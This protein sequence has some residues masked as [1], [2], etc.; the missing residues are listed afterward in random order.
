MKK[1][2]PLLLVFCI[3]ISISIA[4]KI[5]A[6]GGPMNKGFVFFAPETDVA[7]HPKFQNDPL[8]NGTEFFVSWAQVE[9]KEGQYDWS[10]IEKYAKEYSDKGKKITFRISTASFSPN[11]SP[12]WLFENYNVRRITNG[13][14]ANFENGL[15]G[16][17]LLAGGKLTTDSNLVVSGNSS[18]TGQGQILSSGSNSVDDMNS[19]SGYNIGFDFLAKGNAIIK[20]AVKKEDGSLVTIKQWSVS[21]GEKGSRNCFLSSDSI[22]I[23]A[24]IAIVSEN[25][26]ISLDNINISSAKSGFHVGNLAFPNYLDPVFTTKLSNMIKALAQKYKNDDRVSSVCIGGFGRWEELTLGGDIGR[27]ITTDMWKTLGFEQEKYIAHIK[28]IIDVFDSEFKPSGK[29][30]FMCAIG[31]PTEGLSDQTYIDWKITNYLGKKGIGI[32]YNG[33]QAMASE[34]G[35]DATAIFYQMNRF[36]HSPNVNMYYEQ[37]AQINSTVSEVVGHPLSMYNRAIIDQ[38]DYYWM[39]FKDMITPFT[40]KYMQYASES[41]GSALVTRMYNFPDKVTYNS[42]IDKNTYTLYNQWMGIFQTNKSVRAD[43]KGIY[44]ITPVGNYSVVQGKK[45]M[46]GQ[47]KYSIEDRQ[48]YNGMYGAVI[49]MEYLD[50]KSGEF[51]VYCIYEGNRQKPLG[52][53]KKSGTGKWVRKSFYDPGFLAS[54]KNGGR[55]MLTEI[56]ITEGATVSSIGIDFVPAREWKEVENAAVRNV[57]S[58]GKNL[59]DP[60]TLT[61]PYNKVNGTSGISVFVTPDGQ[62]YVSVKTTVKAVRGSERI[63]LTTKEYYMPENAD[64]FYVTTANAPQ[65]TT[66]LEVEVSAMEGNAFLATD[67][68]GKISYSTYS[69]VNDI[70]NESAIKVNSKNINLA[71][72]KPFAGLWVQG[73]GTVKGTV[74]RVMADDR[75]AVDVASFSAE[76]TTGS[77]NVFFEPQPAGKYI[78]RLT[79]ESRADLIKPITLQR[80]TVP[81]IPKRYTLGSE[82]VPK[83]GG[84][85]IVSQSLSKGI[86]KSGGAFTYEVTDINPTFERIGEVAFEADK[87]QILNFVMK[88]ETSAGI[89]KIYWKTKAAGSYTET[90]SAII[91]IVPND[92]QFREFSWPLGTE[93][94]W[95]GTITGIKFSP[96]GNEADTGSISIKR[97]ELHTAGNLT[98]TYNQ[99]LNIADIKPSEFSDSKT[100]FEG[101]FPEIEQLKTFPVTIKRDAIKIISGINRRATQP[102]ITTSG[103]VQ[104]SDSKIDSSENPKD[105]SGKKSNTGLLIISLILIIILGAGVFAGAFF[106]GKGKK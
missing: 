30:L 35:G 59:I 15:S 63:F 103:E 1:F 20:A 19:N 78:I 95:S 8:I 75:I 94:G 73:K 40:S 42:T 57:K 53:V 51:T 11:D 3:S 13:Y 70:K 80:I 93:D 44:R 77:S 7:Y 25:A 38:V 55:D 56:N 101:Y 102:E 36:K 99:K 60:V 82:I 41:A 106:L 81:N 27:N 45:S 24:Q 97:L 87:I 43:S 92:T 9:P 79:S 84:G 32:K 89:C 83:S 34:W 104:N 6:A 21:S 28:K 71:A 10:E 76:I 85:W 90:N 2:L 74:S 48:K 4:G 98:T 31:F 69:F 65:G 72:L 49:N 62:G 91:P 22:P 61:I 37:G 100:Q 17:E 86:K 66:A 14:W 29:P 54:S 39:Y 68:S 88:N 5:F 23:G 67:Q 26:R 105:N 64:V 96:A 18:I 52:V 47:I 33:W 16:Y 46:T 50:D 58:T 12:A